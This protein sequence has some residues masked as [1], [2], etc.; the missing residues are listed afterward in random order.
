[1]CD[2]DRPVGKT[3]EANLR[4]QT[5]FIGMIAFLL[6]TIYI[7][8]VIQRRRRLVRQEQEK[9]DEEAANAKSDEQF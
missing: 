5:I 4:S 8:L 2:L 6:I 1:M 3:P 7:Y 9:R